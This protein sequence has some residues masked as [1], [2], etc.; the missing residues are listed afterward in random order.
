MEHSPTAH[1][2]L[3]MLSWGPKSG[4]DVKAIVD[5]STRFFWAASYGQIYPELRKLA[6]AGLIEAEAG[7]EGG[8]RRTVYR[9]SPAGHER[10]R[11]WLSAEPKTY[12]LRDD[13]LLRLFFAGA[14]PHTAAGT[15]ESKRHYHEGLVE[16]FR[17]IEATGKP[18]GFALAVLR[19]GIEM[20]EW[21]AAWCART[22][23]ELE[24]PTRAA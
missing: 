16:Q 8:R 4:Y 3:G 24:S 12:E 10:L 19:Y 5:N 7:P 13:G 15:L 20:N 21:A 23:A 11:E 9:L 22:A 18:E 6:E 1:V 2:I 17:E 14:A